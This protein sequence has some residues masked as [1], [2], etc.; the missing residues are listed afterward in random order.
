MA[1]QV[2]V[3][4]RCGG[5]RTL[6]LRLAH[7]KAPT[8]LFMPV[9]TLGVVK[10]LSSQ[11]LEAIGFPIILANTYH[12]ML[13]PGLEVGRGE[14]GEGVDVGR[15][16]QQIH[17]SHAVDSVG[18]AGSQSVEES[19]DASAEILYMLGANLRMVAPARQRFGGGGGR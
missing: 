8:P 10:G 15:T 6:E 1:F 5:G 14:R 12:L 4:A 18:V 13:Q 2:T 7:G 17:T 19:G 9:G 3:K 11:D 16:V